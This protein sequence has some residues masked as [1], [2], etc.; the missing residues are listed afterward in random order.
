V[1]GVMDSCPSILV[2]NHPAAPADA[3]A[4]Y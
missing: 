4:S 1:V 2:T 3:N